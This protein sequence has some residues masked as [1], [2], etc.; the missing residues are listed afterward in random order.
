MGSLTQAM[1]QNRDAIVM[2]STQVNAFNQA[3]GNMNN[4]FAN[5][6]NNIVHNHTFKVDPIIINITGADS[7]RNLEP[8]MQTVASTI[9]ANKI[10]QFANNLQNKNKDIIVPIA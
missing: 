10:N 4:A 6:P 3:V 8:A 7:L 9:I 2:L 1:I 5:M